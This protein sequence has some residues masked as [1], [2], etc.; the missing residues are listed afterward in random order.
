MANIFFSYSHRDESLRDELEIHLAALKRQGVIKTWHD[1]RIEAGKEVD[2]AISEY[3]EKADIILLLVSPYLIA[4]DY[5]YDVEMKRAIERHEAGEARVIPVILH[6][7]DWHGLPFGKLMAT[8]KDGKPVSKF[9]NQHDAFYEISQGIRMAAEELNAKSSFG[10]DPRPACP[11]ERTK[12]N[13]LD[14]QLRSSNLRVK[15][16]FTDVEK[17]RFLNDAFEYIAKFFEGSLLELRTRNAD[18]ESDFRRIDANHFV[19][20][21]YMSGTEVSRCRIWQGGRRGFP[22]G[23]A[24][25]AGDSHGDT[26]YN[27]SISVD[28]DGYT[29]FLKPMGMGYHR[30]SENE[31]MAFEGAA[32]YLWG[33]L[34]RP[35]QE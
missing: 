15:K 9:P 30:P 7:C 18:I 25:S 24:Y 1:R 27:E 20:A 14:P 2:H 5:C 34:I 26:S 28:D 23:I 32:E 19:A 10:A 22:G 3:L 6:P 11:R 8:P 12:K 16:K 29:L 33:M 17:D 31:K 13:T 35:L 4:S 21:V